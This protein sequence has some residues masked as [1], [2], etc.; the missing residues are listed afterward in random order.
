MILTTSQQAHNFC[1]YSM[2]HDDA[3]RSMWETWDDDRNSETLEPFVAELKD[4]V[5]R[6]FG[7]YTFKGPDLDQV[8][9]TAIDSHDKAE[10]RW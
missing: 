10:N 3:M 9:L 5:S 1:I 2:I 4:A 6:V 7:A 8:A